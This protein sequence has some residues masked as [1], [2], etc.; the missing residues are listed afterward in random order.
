MASNG[1]RGRPSNGTGSP[2]KRRKSAKAA[3][4]DE[5]MT[6]FAH[7]VPDINSYKTPKDHTD[8][9]PLKAE[10]DVRLDTAHYSVSP[11]V[12]WNAL[13]R[14]RKFTSKASQT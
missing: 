10:L 9:L 11:G 14:Y 3:P 4:V 8:P 6:F 12:S 1:K 2:V 7:K 5:P 13:R